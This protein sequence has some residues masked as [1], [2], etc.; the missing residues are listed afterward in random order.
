MSYLSDLDIFKALSQF[1]EPVEFNALCD[2]LRIE[3]NLT[4]RNNFFKR[5]NGLVNGGS[6]TLNGSVANGRYVYC[7]GL[8]SGAANALQTNEFVLKRVDV[9]DKSARRAHWISVISLII[10]GISV[11]VAVFT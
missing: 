2:T 4:L 7:Y 1:P 11:L 10:S 3:D 9:A 5:L 6:L 8:S